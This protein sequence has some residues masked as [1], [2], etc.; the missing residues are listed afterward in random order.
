MFLNQINLYP[1]NNPAA[2]G[3]PM[4]FA[5]QSTSHKLLCILRLIETL[6]LSLKQSNFWKLKNSFVFFKQF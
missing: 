5:I 1:S 4:A 3:V 6:E 2:K